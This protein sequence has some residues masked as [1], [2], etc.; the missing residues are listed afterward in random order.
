MLVPGALN[1]VILGRGTVGAPSSPYP[2]QPVSG[3][4]AWYRG[5]FMAGTTWTDMSG[6][7]HDITGGTAPTYSSSDAAFNNQPTA[8]F[9]I[10]SSQFIGGTGATMANMIN[11][12]TANAFTIYGIF[13][14]TTGSTLS[15]D[16]YYGPS[17]GG[18]TPQAIN[19]NT[20]SNVMNIAGVNN[21][22][23]PIVLQGKLASLVYYDGTTLSYKKSGDSV[24]T[25]AVAP[26]STGDA[27]LIA[28]DLGGGFSTC[29]IAEIMAW[30]TDIGS[31]NRGTVETYISN[32]YGI[33]V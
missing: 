16:G 1:A 11:Q 23:N 27:I 3:M 15:T 20:T 5:D 24:A 21:F 7:S 19:F 8:Q 28:K 13:S 32:R 29:T 26:F 2:A 17:S 31:T 30:G 6:N 9:A 33:T 22:G 4:T 14:F 25:S 12:A 18:R 10:A